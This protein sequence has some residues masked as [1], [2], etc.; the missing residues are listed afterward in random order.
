[1]S[2]YIY[3]YIN[4]NIYIYIYIDVNMC[5][6][7]YRCQYIHMY[8][9][10]YIYIYIYIRMYV[11]IYISWFI[12]SFYA[13]QVQSIRLYIFSRSLV[14]IQKH[15]FAVSGIGFR[16]PV[17]FV[18][19]S[20]FHRARMSKRHLQPEQD[21]LGAEGPDVGESLGEVCWASIP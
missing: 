10:I 11:Y 13:V 9:C 12:C 16:G 18:M 5:I 8:T 19:P 3:I 17:F 4:V 2:I 1:M 7:I 15:G 20:G 6:Y 21:T 14:H